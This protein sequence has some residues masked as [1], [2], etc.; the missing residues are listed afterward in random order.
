MLP[1][2]PG[3]AARWSALCIGGVITAV[4]ACCWANYRVDLYGLFGP[5]DGRARLVYSNERSGKYLLS[6]RYVPEHFD[7]LLIGSSISDNWDTSRIDSLRMY[8]GSI[9]GGNISE[10]KLVADNVLDRKNLKVVVFCVYQYLTDTHGR[11][12]SGMDEREFRSAFGSLRLLRDYATVLLIGRGL[13]R[14]KWNASGAYDFDIE[15]QS[16]LSWAKGRKPTNPETFALD[17]VAYSEF[18]E[19][20]R[21]ARSQGAMIVRVCP[22]INYDRWLLSQGEFEKYF[23]RMAALFRA[24]DLSIDFNTTEFDNFR[25][26]HDTFSDGFHLSKDSAVYVM[27]VLNRSIRYS[28]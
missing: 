24:E 17:P 12:E 11:K 4:G 1:F 14:Q 5:D 7:G 26:R 16:R 20:V 9:N 21:R 13:M 3:R 27:N 18:G 15:K 2:K 25:K 23:A 6:L 28:Q 19:L 8:N 22:P 10:A